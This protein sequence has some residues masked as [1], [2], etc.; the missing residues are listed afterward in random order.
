MLSTCAGCAAPTRQSQRR[1]PGA[2]RQ[3]NRATLSACGFSYRAGD[4]FDISI[5]DHVVTVDQPV[6][7]GGDDLGPTPTELF[8]AGLAS[9]VAFY[10]RR[11]LRRHKLGATGLAVETS[12]RMGT[13]PARVSDIDIAIHLPHELP[14]RRQDGLLAVASRCTV[15]N[16]ITT[17]PRIGITL[18]ADLEPQ[19]ATLPS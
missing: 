12:Y 11:Y 18:A 1:S 15:H 14:P 10:A 6:D 13:K 2:S 7:S 16:S 9:C 5:R 19:L 8:V 4:R 17:T 3:L